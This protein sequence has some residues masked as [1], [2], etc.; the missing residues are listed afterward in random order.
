MC[1]SKDKKSNL[2]NM[3]M[4]S[5]MDENE[6][7]SP[8]RFTATASSS[9]AGNTITKPNS[10]TLEQGGMIPKLHID[11]TVERIFFRQSGGLRKLEES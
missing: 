6:A 8:N 9:K 7:S 11:S 4:N 1:M 3:P 10:I 5:M 2:G